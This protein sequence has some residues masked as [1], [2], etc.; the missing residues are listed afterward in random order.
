M[1]I[2]TLH[3]TNSYHASS[4]GIRTTYQALLQ[5]AN[6]LARPVRLVVPGEYDSIEEVG[7][8]GRIYS[9]RASRLPVGDRRYRTILPTYLLRRRQHP[10]W[11]ILREEKP[12]L[13][14]VADKLCLPYVAGLLRKGWIP[15]VARPTLVGMSCERFD[16]T[17]A[18]YLSDHPLAGRLA[19]WYLGQIYIPQFDFH[20]SNSIY[21]A[22]ELKASALPK[23]RR[24]VFVVPMGADCKVFN[25]RRRSPEL[26]RRLF[27]KTNGQS[28]SVLLLF[29]GRLAPEKGLGLLL[30]TMKRLRRDAAKDYRLLVA[31]DGPLRLEFQAEADR[32]IP[33]RVVF[34]GHIESR[35]E[36]ADLFA[37]CDL[38]LHPNA[39]E[40]FGIAPLEAMAAGLPLVAPNRGGVTTYANSENAWLSEPHGNSLAFTVRSALADPRILH[41]KTQKARQTAMDHSWECVT[42]HLFELY[43]RLHSRAWK[44]SGQDP[45]MNLFGQSHPFSN[46]RWASGKASA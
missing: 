42:D 34:L 15:G 23:H 10:L 4:G 43:D 37:N 14:E 8:F 33:G 24:T 27:E 32:Q 40:P 44:G 45:L 9:I 1:T 31:G 12:D 5:A 3:I 13:I 18:A 6:R 36:L 39:R 28:N 7:D 35:E 22:Q 17:V 30:E 46:T 29:A 21:T 25:P 19:S 16:D 2:K 41:R 20:L 11:R 26:R 38:F